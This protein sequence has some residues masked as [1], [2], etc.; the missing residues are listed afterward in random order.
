M[1]ED[2]PRAS[3]EL[4]FTI[5][6]PP[7]SQQSTRSEKDKFAELMRKQIGNSPY[8]L[9]GDVRVEIEWS[10]HEQYRYESDAAPDVDNILKPLLD[11]LCG[12]QGVLIDDCQVQA[13]DC[14]WIDWPD[15]RSSP[16]VSPGHLNRHLSI[17]STAHLRP[18]IKQELRRSSGIPDFSRA[19]SRIVRPVAWASFTSTAVFS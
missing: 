13:V 18:R 1:S 4:E 12:P 15:P 6:G 14:R 19:K 10:L 16:L 3:G 9:S 11:A 7:V 5:S 8:L 17:A 2:E